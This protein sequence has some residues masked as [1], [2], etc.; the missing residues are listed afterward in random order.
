MIRAEEIIHP[1]LA[2]EGR[3]TRESDRLHAGQLVESRESAVGEGP[4]RST[5][6]CLTQAELRRYNVVN[7]GG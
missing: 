3:R 4:N 5:R 1:S 2:G 6:R 7:T